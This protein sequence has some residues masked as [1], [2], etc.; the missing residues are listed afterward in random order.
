[1]TAIAAQ[2]WQS[3]RFDVQ[4][5]DDEPGTITFC[6]SGPLT[7]RDMYSTLSPADLCDVLECLTAH[8]RVHCFD[9]T[10]V[11]Y[12]DGAGVRMLLNHRDYCRACGIR[13]I[14]EGMTA[15][16]L[17]ALKAARVEDT[18]CATATV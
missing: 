11:P 13:M 10:G 9:M 5:Y 16:V 6:L 8:A 17:A 1:M 15:R 2:M 12:M 18:L 4:R 3:T 7:A 14:V